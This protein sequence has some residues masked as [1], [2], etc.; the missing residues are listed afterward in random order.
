MLVVF[1]TP[2]LTLVC[3]RRCLFRLEGSPNPLLQYWQMCGFS[4]VCRFICTWQMEILYFF[5]NLRAWYFESW[6]N[7]QLFKKSPTSFSGHCLTLSELLLGNVFP[8][9]L[10]ILFPF[11]LESSKSSGTASVRVQLLLLILAIGSLVGGEIFWL[12]GLFSFLDLLII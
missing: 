4:P 8:Q 1:F 12:S 2:V 9:K 3:I 11:P 5:N 7:D 6:S 10:Q